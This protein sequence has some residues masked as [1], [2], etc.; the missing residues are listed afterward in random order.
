MKSIFSTYILYFRIFAQNYKSNKDYLLCAWR[1]LK[2]ICVVYVKGVIKKLWSKNITHIPFQ[3][4]NEVWISGILY[5][6]PFFQYQ[7]SMES[8][9]KYFGCKDVR[10]GEL[11][12]IN[13]V[14]WKILND[15][16]LKNFKWS[17]FLKLC[18][19]F[20]GSVDNVGTE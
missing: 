14:F 4:A 19:I 1:K 20:V 2:K 15:L 6:D 10:L 3:Y 12:L 17:Y 7:K 11:S 9:W 13:V 5:V 8:S 18:S 16:F